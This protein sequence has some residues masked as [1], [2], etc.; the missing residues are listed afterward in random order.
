MNLIDSFVPCDHPQNGLMDGSII[1][2]IIM[3]NA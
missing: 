2:Y 1:L 3:C